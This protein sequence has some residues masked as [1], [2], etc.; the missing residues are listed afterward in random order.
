MITLDVTYSV[1]GLIGPMTDTVTVPEQYTMDDVKAGIE[2][3]LT[4]VSAALDKKL[5]IRHI[6]FARPHRG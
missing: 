6:L 4:E 1:N 2:I 3:L 5:S